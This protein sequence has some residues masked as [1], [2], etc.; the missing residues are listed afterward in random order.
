MQESPSI[1]VNEIPEFAGMTFFFN[2]SIFK[3]NISIF[4]EGS[5]EAKNPVFF[6]I[7]K[8]DSSLRSE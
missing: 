5:N 8:I 7:N 3:F 6:K 1:A 2:I 4:K